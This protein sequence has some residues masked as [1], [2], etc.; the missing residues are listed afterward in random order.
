MI[1]S[2]VQEMNKLLREVPTIQ[3]WLSGASNQFV[4]VTLNKETIQIG[5]G[6]YNFLIV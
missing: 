5:K 1:V 3:S 2:V 4:P 6:I